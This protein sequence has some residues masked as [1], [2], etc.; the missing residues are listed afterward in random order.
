MDIDN[1]T[2]KSA[3]IGSTGNLRA[4]IGT[5]NWTT[6]DLLSDY[7]ISDFR[8]IYVS[9]RETSNNL[10]RGSILVPVALFKKGIEFDVPLIDGKFNGVKYI[11]ETQISVVSTS[12]TYNAIDVIGIY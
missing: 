4:V 11:S 10:S 3:K 12:A 5:E 9:G 7:K 2:E 6:T 8:Y 1:L